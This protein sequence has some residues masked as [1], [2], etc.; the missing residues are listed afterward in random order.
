[1][2]CAW[3]CVLVWGRSMLCRMLCPR[4]GGNSG[5][6]RLSWNQDIC[7]LNV[8]RDACAYVYLCCTVAWPKGLGVHIRL[9]R[10]D[11]VRFC[12]M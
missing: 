11:I 2:A 9:C 12:P 8:M 5:N 10:R 6:D 1:M 3:V 7:I 4:R